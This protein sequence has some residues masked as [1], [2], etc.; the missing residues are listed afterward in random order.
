MPG[1]LTSYG[2][3]NVGKRYRLKMSFDKTVP[4]DMLDLVSVTYRQYNDCYVLAFSKP[5][6]GAIASP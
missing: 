2:S 1:E 3:L 6:V 5:D 4:G